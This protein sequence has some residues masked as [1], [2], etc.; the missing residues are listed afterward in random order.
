ML[1]LL[2]QSKDSVCLLA[3]PWWKIRKTFNGVYNS[4]PDGAAVKAQE[5]HFVALHI[6]LPGICRVNDQQQTARIAI[7]MHQL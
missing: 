7:F 4:D 5:F 6:V 3:E 1:I 2:M